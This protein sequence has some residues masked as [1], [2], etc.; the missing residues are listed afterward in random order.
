MKQKISVDEVFYFATLLFGGSRFK[1]GLIFR[2]LVALF[3]RYLNFCGEEAL[4]FQLT[5]LLIIKAIL[6]RKIFLRVD[7]NA[8]ELVNKTKLD[9][10]WILYNNICDH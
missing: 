9:V 8:I 1:E 2:V 10:P 3:Q 6:L 7:C 4:L 5:Y